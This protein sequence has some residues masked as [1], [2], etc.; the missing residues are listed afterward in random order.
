MVVALSLSKG[1]KP[2]KMGMRFDTPRGVLDEAQRDTGEN[3]HKIDFFSTL[4]GI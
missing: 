2:F 3:F 1:D 4:L